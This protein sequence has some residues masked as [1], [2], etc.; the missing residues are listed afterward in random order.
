MSGTQVPTIEQLQDNPYLAENLTDEQMEAMMSGADTDGQGDTDG[1]ASPGTAGT[2][3]EVK[4][5]GEGGQDDAAAEAVKAAAAATAAP[6]AAPAQPNAVI[7]APDGKHTIPYSAL[8]A[9][10][11][12]A[13]RAEHL[14]EAQAEEIARL[15]A[16]S[17]AAPNAQATAAPAAL[18]EADLEALEVDL[19]E[20]AKALRAQAATIT[21]LT[22]AV[23]TLQRE[24]EIQVDQKAAQAQDEV[25]AAILANADLKAWRDTASAK[26]NPDPLMWNRAADLDAVL[27]NDP[28]WRDRPV[29]ERLAHVA[30]SVKSLYGVPPQQQDTTAS[31]HAKAAAA[32]AAAGANGTQVPT[33]MG[34]IPGGT[35][36]PVDEA[37]AMGSKSG[38]ELMEDFALLT[39]DQIE[40]KLAKAGF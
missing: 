9:E 11:E 16:G 19:P 28:A 37:S 7:Q 33:S 1:G 30:T 35:M 24:R 12:R 5:P 32:L 13:M 20:V 23:T 25:E 3:A 29:A 39:P 4:D 10:R 36:P 38:V 31:L 27:R 8:Q 6:A 34:S 14:L 40:A 18:S 17:T 15:K 21:Q 26:D 22:S 2:Q